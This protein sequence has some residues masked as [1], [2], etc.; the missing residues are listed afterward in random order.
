M[1]ILKNLEEE[2]LDATTWRT[3]SLLNNQE[4]ERESG[5]RKTGPSSIGV[6]LRIPVARAFRF[7]RRLRLGNALDYLN[8]FGFDLVFFLNSP[9]ERV[10]SDRLFKV[11]FG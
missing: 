8:A 9:E 4:R 10:S 6:L 3:N 2:I 11:F 1:R 5:F 7:E